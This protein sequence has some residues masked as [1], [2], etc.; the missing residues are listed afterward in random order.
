MPEEQTQL[1]ALTAAIV[2]AHVSNNR[3]AVGDVANLVQHVHGALSGLGQTPAEQEPAKKTPVVS[4]RASVKPDHIVCMA[5]GK[6]QK[7]LR[8]NL[9]T[10]HGMT[11]DQY[12]ADYGLPREYPMTAPNYSEQR[13]SMAKNIGLGLKKAAPDAPAPA[14]RA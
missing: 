7:T 13:R 8:R 1:I 14:K 4:A 5:C 10:A 2:S 6:K 11:P 3:V 12:R 9:Q